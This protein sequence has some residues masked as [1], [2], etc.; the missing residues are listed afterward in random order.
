MNGGGDSNNGHSEA[1]A[2]SASEV[3]S[4]GSGTP[5]PAAH[6]FSKGFYLELAA[7]SESIYE[8]GKHQ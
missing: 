7:F 3:S 1:A 5:T 8:R 2:A 4:N 6:K